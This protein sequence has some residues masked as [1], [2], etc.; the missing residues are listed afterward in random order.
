MSRRRSARPGLTFAYALAFVGAVGVLVWFAAALV[1]W[2][3]PV[4]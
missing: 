4:P 3:L 1:M 2:A